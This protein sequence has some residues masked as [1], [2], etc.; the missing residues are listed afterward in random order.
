MTGGIAVDRLGRLALISALTLMICLAPAVR[1]Q[2][3]AA[4][5]D[6]APPA[7]IEELQQRIE[8]VMGETHTNGV[9]IA[10]VSR[11]E[12]LWVAGLG[13]ADVA[14]GTPA[15]ADTLFRIGSTSK[16]FVALA[17]LQLVEEGRLDLS[18]PIRELI[19]EIAFE[20]RWQATDPVRVVHL[21]EHTTGFD[22]LHLPE[23]IYPAT[24]E[25]TVKEALDF[26]PHSR[27]CRWRPGTRYSYC[28]AGPAVAAYIVEKITGQRFEDYVQENLFD[29]LGMET[30]SY[31]LTP[32]VEARLTKL[33][34]PDGVTPY[35][36]W[37]I[38]MRPAGSINASPREMARYVRMFLQ[39]GSL[40]G[41]EIV[42]PASIERMEKPT[43]TPAARLGMATGY[44]LANYTSHYEGFVFHGHNGGV[45]GGLTDMSYLPEEGL[46]YIFMINSGSG[47]AY[48]RIM[49]LIRGY[50]T[51]D[52][53]APEPPPTARVPAAL[54]ARYSG[55][56]EPANPRSQLLFFIER[57]AG[58]QRLRVG[59]EGLELAPLLGGEGDSYAA[60]SERFFREDDETV[61]T[62]ALLPAEGGG[63]F[64]STE[65][66]TLRKIPGWV[67]WGQ[68][69]L[70]GVIA[71]LL[72]SAV[73]F[74][75]V[76]IPR[77]FFGG[78][79]GKPHLSLR[80]W[81]LVSTLCLLAFVALF[82]V[83]SN[84]PDVLEILGRPSLYSVA[85]M[86]SSLAFGLTAYWSLWVALR[87]YRRPVHRLAYWHS[88]LVALACSLA[89]TYLLY[90]GAL[91]FRTWV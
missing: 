26:H 73:L 17:M 8:G 30:A 59:A 56:Y 55:F 42:S 84:H 77:R 63:T 16:S 48:T 32:E 72:A 69:G 13:E 58:I 40:D 18:T 20:N 60:V 62:L 91:G 11:D 6:E 10:L 68:V 36:Y 78:L 14:A 9:G 35:P 89:A 49:K 2:E 24:N 64:I 19:P 27:R 43:T 15:T 53:T 33:Y 25:T 67:A 7:S 66:L 57:L 46:G 28:N 83:S 12:P 52:L 87:S 76:W 34:K 31:L 81:P 79:K 4:E 85:L 38:S 88:L 61:A 29:P 21:L 23:Y 65:D 39:R 71:L 75:L 5:E 51:R 86:V 3:E 22:D 80:V 1:A 82:V 54:Q 44:G 74:A 47:G 70:A 50:L 41:T 37:Y 90:W 45:N